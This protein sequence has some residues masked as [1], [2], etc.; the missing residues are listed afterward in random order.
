MAPRCGVENCRSRKYE[1]GEDGYLYCENGHRKGEQIA[2]EDEDQF[3]TAIRVTTRKKVDKEESEKPEKIYTGT[4]GIDLYVKCLQLILRHQLAYLI[5]KKGLPAELETVVQ[6][7]WTLRILQLGHKIRNESQDSGSSQVFSTQESE[8]EADD[9]PLILP[10]RK[11]KL[12]ENPTLI[13]CLALCYLGTLTLRLPVTPGDIYTWTTEEDMPYLNAI[14]LITPPMRNRLPAT[15]HSAFSPYSLLNL[16][17]FY[18]A[19]ANL[20]AGFELK[21]SIAWPALNVPVLLFRYL[22]DLA[23]PLE[24]YDAT[25]RL[26][27]KLGYDFALYVS[28]RQK[29][30]ITSLPEARLISCLVI[31]VKLIFPFDD[32]KR[33]PRSVTEPAAT[34]VDWAAWSRL[35]KAA[36]VEERGGRHR[37]TTEELTKV[38]EKDVFSMSG[39]ELDQYLDF[40][41]ANFVDEMNIQSKSSD[42]AFQA[43]MYSL[44][45]VAPDP[46][47]QPQKTSADLQHEK[48]LELVRA[49]HDTTEEV[50]AVADDEGVEVMRPGARY[51]EY[52]KESNM[53]LHAARFY[54]EAARIS[55]LT[56]EMLI[57][58]VWHIERKIAREQSRR[59]QAV[60]EENAAEEVESPEVEMLDADD[61]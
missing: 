12:Q 46:A 55:G 58:C 48:K 11:K 50:R 38:E 49:V 44:F 47:S 9:D 24:V 21:Y 54:E 37:Y 3:E 16:R 19:Y 22:K 14:R 6:D 39:G 41:L 31:C 42:D 56:L 26:G 33:H 34:S 32:T 18:T 51:A 60:S 5:Q 36:R 4:K 53:P 45:P 57:R 59:K 61:D 40:Y 43:A 30:D 1:E 17:R 15:Y 28:P 10:A 35:M 52:T 29:L 25:I 20:L 23:L 7:L 27:E 13:D 8:T 2:G